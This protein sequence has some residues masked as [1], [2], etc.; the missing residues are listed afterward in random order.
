MSE[1]DTTMM[2]DGTDYAHTVSQ[3][4]DPLASAPIS[5]GTL[6]GRYVVLGPLGAGSMGVVYSAHD[7]EL[8]RK[9]A[10]KLVRLDEAGSEGSPGHA[11]LLREA[12][13]LA[14]LSHPNVLNL[15]NL[16]EIA[17]MR[18]RH[19]EAQRYFE[20]ALAIFEGAL[21]PKHLDLAYPLTG[22]GRALLAQGAA[23]Q[24][25]QYLERALALR[26][27]AKVPA[28]DLGWTRFALAQ[29]LWA[30]ERDRGRARSL[31][32]QARESFARAGPKHKK[33][34]ALVERWLGQSRRP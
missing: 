32:A 18:R 30:V 5:P 24:A 31:A 4:S 12:Q 9:V 23:K 34:L 27:G 22:L 28:G 20:R 1:H 8:D 15:Q 29:A 11:R 2:G 33:D 3:G 26:E 17:L 19:D 16:G 6:V 14:R 13:A 25:T 10:L 21:E 7:P